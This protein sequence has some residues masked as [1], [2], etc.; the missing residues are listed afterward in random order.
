MVSH[1]LTTFSGHRRSGSSDTEA[2]I[3]YMTL[4]DRMIKRSGDFMEGNS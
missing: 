1:Q 3:F 2:D 4:Q